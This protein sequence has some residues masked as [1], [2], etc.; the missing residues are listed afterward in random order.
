MLLVKAPKR[1]ELGSLNA[2]L[3]RLKLPMGLVLD[4]VDISG[5]NVHLEGDPFKI[6]LEKPG[7]LE[8]VVSEKSLEAFLNEKAP[9]GLSGFEATLVNDKIYIQANMQMILTIR[10]A[11][12]CTLRVEGGKQLFV[13]LESVDVLGVGAKNLVQKQLDSLNPILDASDLP[14]DATIT[15]AKVAKGEIVVRGEVEP[16]SV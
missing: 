6:E 13:D 3:E 11:A 2:R 15:S 9:G 8:V 7:A 14:L 4:R 5:E 1:L 16:K 12:V 10:A